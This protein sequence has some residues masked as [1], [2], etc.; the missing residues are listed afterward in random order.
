MD[1]KNY[2]TLVFQELARKVVDKEVELLRLLQVKSEKVCN[3]LLVKNEHTQLSYLTKE[4]QIGAVAI[5]KG[6]IL[7]KLLSYLHRL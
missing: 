2:A 5:P 7:D 6:L 4:E 1:T 3:D